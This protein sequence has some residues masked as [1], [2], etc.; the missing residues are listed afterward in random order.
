MNAID[1]NAMTSEEIRKALDVEKFK[2]DSAV[3][4]IANLDKQISYLRKLFRRAEKNKGYAIRYNLRM[5]LSIVSG[6]K[7]MFHHYAAVKEERIARLRLRV[8]DT[9]NAQR[10][11]IEVSAEDHINS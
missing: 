1:I 5:Q 7:V 4:Q 3:R 9:T 6:V 8:D 2:L 10:V 11:P